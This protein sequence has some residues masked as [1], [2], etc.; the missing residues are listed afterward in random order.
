[1]KEINSQ[2]LQGATLNL[3]KFDWEIEGIAEKAQQKKERF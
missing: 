1:L 3:E 2:S